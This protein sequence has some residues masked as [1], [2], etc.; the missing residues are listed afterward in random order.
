MLMIY[1]P[2]GFDQFL[3]EMSRMTQEDFENERR[4]AELNAKYDLVPLGAVP[5]HPDDAK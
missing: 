5:E 3:E 1:Q 4:M 2:G